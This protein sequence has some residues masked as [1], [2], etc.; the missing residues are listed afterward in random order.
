MRNHRFVDNKCCTDMIIVM[1][2]A[3]NK[4]TTKKTI[5]DVV[6]LELVL[7]HAANYAADR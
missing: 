1:G 6:I 7:G 4:K 2:A 5:L 3:K